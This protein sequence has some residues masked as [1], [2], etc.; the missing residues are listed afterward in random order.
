MDLVGGANNI[1]WH[2]KNICLEKSLAVQW[3]GLGISTAGV[4]S[5]V[6]ELRSPKPRGMT[7]KKK[8]T[9]QKTFQ[10]IFRDS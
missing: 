4:Q 6:R 3:L 1:I 8:K 7:K 2:I 10:S 5:L 9:I